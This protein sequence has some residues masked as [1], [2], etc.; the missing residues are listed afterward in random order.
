ARAMFEAEE[1]AEAVAKVI[2]PWV[3]Q[4]QPLQRQLQIQNAVNSALEGFVEGLNSGNRV[5]DQFI[6]S[7]RW[8]SGRIRL[9]SGG[10]LDFGFNLIG[11]FLG[12]LFGGYTPPAV[13]TYAA[14]DPIQQGL[15]EALAQRRQLEA[16]V[17]RLK[18][19]VAEA[20]RHL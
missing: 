10:L 14:P 8:E 3:E 6:R 7:L 12:S 5:L 20:E 4:L 18:A 13:R 9:D 15:A 19:K 1:S 16:E 11:Q 17:E 2:A